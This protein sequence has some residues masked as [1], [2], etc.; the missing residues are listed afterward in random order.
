M[1]ILK[2]KYNYESATPRKGCLILFISALV[3]Q[4]SAVRLHKILQYLDGYKSDHRLHGFLHIG[5][6][7]AVFLKLPKPHA[8]YFVYELYEAKN[9]PEKGRYSPRLL[10]VSKVPVEYIKD[11]LT[12]FRD[13]LY[14]AKYFNNNTVPGTRVKTIREWQI[15][16]ALNFHSDGR[17]F[18]DKPPILRS[19]L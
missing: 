4:N 18:Q 7:Y 10:A 14:K 13:E 16:K 5:V 1:D 3:T 17:T 2:H 15:D 9:V 8:K 11:Q 19:V 12:T 6:D